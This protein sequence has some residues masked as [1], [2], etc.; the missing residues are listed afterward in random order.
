MRIKDLPSSGKVETCKQKTTVCTK[1]GVWRLRF[2][3]SLI[4][5]I[6]F[7]LDVNLLINGRVHR[8][9]IR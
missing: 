7:F 4:D 5:L 8:V 9:R 1:K 3:E 6:K 2:N